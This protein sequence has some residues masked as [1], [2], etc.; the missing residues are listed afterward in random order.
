MKSV[1]QN[2]LMHNLLLLL[3]ENETISVSRIA[4]ILDTSESTIRRK[5]DILNDAL[6]ETG[7]GYI[8]K[9]P[10]RGLHLVVEDRAAINKLFA[11]Y[12]LKNIMTGE[13]QIY[14]YLILILSGKNNKI[15][16]NELSERVYDS[17]SVVRKNLTV[18]EEWLSLF[19]LHLSIKKN[20]GITLKGSE[21]SIRL[22]IKH[23]VINNDLYSIDE[24]IHI[25]AQGIDLE[26]LKQCI[27][28]IESEWNFKFTEESF[29]SMLVYAALAISRF[30]HTVL[31]ISDTER[32][33]VLKY[34]E[35][36]WSKSLFKMI[37]EKFSVEIGEDEIIFF[38]VQLLCSYLIHS[39]NFEENNAYKYDEKLKTFITRII[40]VVSD[41]INVDLTQDKELYY[42]LLNHIRPAIFRMRFEKH[43]T[44][45]LTNFIKEEYKQT[46][47]VSWALSILFEEY[48][49]INIS[50]TELSYITLYIQS[51]LDRMSQPIKMV[52]VTELGMGLN[53]LFCNKIKISVPK[54]EKI[55]IISLHDFNV[56]ML[57]QYDLIVTTSSL[58]ISSDKV[59]QLSSLL[60]DNGIGLI[61]QKIEMLKSRQL[62]TKKKFDVSCHTLFDPK[63]IFTHLKVK[64]K[65]AL[66]SLLSKHLVSLGYVSSKYHAS[67]LKREKTVSTYIGN[68]VAIPHGNSGLV[69]ESKVAIAILDEAIQWDTE[70]EVDTVFLLV[71]RISSHEDSKR[72][73]L[74]Y[75]G[76][77][78]LIETDEKLKYLRSL[79]EDE[80]YKYLV[81]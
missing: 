34:N 61:K 51:S 13:R 15:T 24:S 77:L 38:A 36:S 54:V 39:E 76:F 31:T 30:S 47:R 35:Y 64:D 20:V 26:L 66:L 63:L 10:R 56:K 74:F 41:V 55:A 59:I 19:E 79:P 72:V 6:K 5:I 75:K 16:L 70:N 7:Y 33:T 27:F 81:Q 40:S 53:Q 57:D 18:C 2:A 37:E 44:Q 3:C 78:E 21:E 9:S 23:I 12:E 73:Q 62:E 32:K 80:L 14:K 1:K 4:A 25:F 48:Y 29:H 69:N 43:S 11:N 49:G 28:A 42:G 60:S 65:E 8:D 68:S 67:I 71:F 45:T 22:A 17:I 58:K 46:Y 52:L 50:S